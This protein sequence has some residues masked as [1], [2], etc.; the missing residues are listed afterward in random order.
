MQ[1]FPPEYR[2][3]ECLR[4]ARA[5]RSAWLADN[6][7][8]RTRMRDAA[9]SADRDLREFGVSWVFSV[10]R[11]ADDEK[12]VLLKSHYPKV[13]EV[14]RKREEHESATPATL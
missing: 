8:L 4:I 14:T 1:N 13:A 9:S 7:A 12:D 11:M 5:L 10:A 3:E 6:R 2:C